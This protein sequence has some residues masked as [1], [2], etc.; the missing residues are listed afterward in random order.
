MTSAAV[1]YTWGNAALGASKI[2]SLTS[3]VPILSSVTGAIATGLNTAYAWILGAGPLVQIAAVAA[4]VYVGAKVVKA[5]WNGVKKVFSFLSDIRTKENV[6][7]KRKLPNGLNLYEFEYKKEFKDQAGHGR[8]EGFMA[9]E[10]E[11]LYP[12]AVKVESSGYKSINYSLI[13]I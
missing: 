7:F 4:I 8:Y 2:A 12:N 1:S 13:G 11:K 6:T 5:V 3:N 10:V 9:H